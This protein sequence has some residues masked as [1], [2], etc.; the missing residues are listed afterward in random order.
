MFAFVYTLALVGVAQATVP[1]GYRYVGS[2]VVSEGRVVYWYWNDAHVDV[3]ADGTA[4]VARL[5]ARAAE[6]DRERPYVAVIRCD[7]RAYREYGARGAFESIDDGEPIAAVWRAGCR[8]GRTVFAAAPSAAGGFASAP[9][10][11]ATSP[12]PVTPPPSGAPAAP[13]R[14]TSARV[15]ATTDP[16]R[17]DACVR[18]AETKG[19]PAGDATLTNA[20]GTPVEV[21]LCYRGAGSGAFDCA[22]V[23]RGRHTESLAP[24]ATRVL[25]EYRRGRNRGIAMVACKGALGTV[26]PKLDDT[27]TSGCYP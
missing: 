16:R 11:A 26:F 27:A 6:V 9:P 22:A 8:D 4:F 10:P 15:D 12:S 23:A 13:A 2:R 7:Q 24:G 17:A 5:Y 20:C 18:F 14:S 21:T 25:P 3:V 1:P 19:T